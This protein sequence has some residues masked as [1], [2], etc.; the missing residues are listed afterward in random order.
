M[1]ARISGLSSDW[2]INQLTHWGGFLWFM[3]PCLLG[4]GPP[5]KPKMAWV[6]IP[7]LWV[8]HPRFFPG[9]QGKSS[10]HLSI[11]CEQNYGFTFFN[12][13]SRSR[14]GWAHRCGSRVQVIPGHRRCCATEFPTRSIDS[15]K[16]LP[17]RS[18]QSGSGGRM[19]KRQRLDYSR[20][21]LE[22]SVETIFLLWE[23]LEY[24][25]RFSFQ[26]PR[27]MF[28]KCCVSKKN[29]SKHEFSYC[30]A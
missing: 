21:D 10:G 29:I 15:D 3:E 23:S 24:A 22:C 9:I 6:Y 8:N 30:N 2:D 27:F 12:L 18:E 20:W 16:I 28:D 1:I 4:M 19:F 26:N 13:F 14:V 5:K 11:R 17:Q 7:S 25:H